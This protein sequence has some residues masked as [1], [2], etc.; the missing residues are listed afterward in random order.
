MAEANNYWTGLAANGIINDDTN[1]SSA[2][3]S[4]QVL[5]FPDDADTTYTL[6][7]DLS[8][9]DLSCVRNYSAM[10]FG[11]SASSTTEATHDFVAG[12][13]TA[14]ADTISE[15]NHG[16]VTGQA[17]VFTTTAAD[18]P[19]P[20]VAGT[21]Y[22]VIVV[23][24]DTYQ[25]ATSYAN[26][27]AGTQVDLTDGG[28]G[29][30]TAT[31][32][33]YVPVRIVLDGT[34]LQMLDKGSGTRYFSLHGASTVHL[35]GSGVAE[36]DGGDAAENTSLWIRHSGTL[37]L[38][39]SNSVPAIFATIKYIGGTGTVY[40]RNV[41]S[42]GGAAVPIN[43]IADT[44][45]LYTYSRLAAVSQ[46]AGI[47]RHHDG[48]VA[49]HQSGT[50]TS[51]TQESGSTCYYNSVGLLGGCDIHGKLDLST[52]DP[53]TKTVGVASTTYPRFY[54][55]CTVLDPAGVVTWAEEPEFV[56]CSIKDCVVDF[57]SNKKYTV[58]D[59]T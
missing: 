54:K 33:E 21:T 4:D 45:K 57:G 11:G 47:W 35:L 36:Y 32:L 25:V 29:T 19:D 15:V 43:L 7:G 5:I 6:K 17:I 52:E 40:L 18:L 49:T 41:T 38:G 2:L 28:S 55:G 48:G 53:R 59:I 27:I 22:Y 3:A 51:I 14:A 10:A 31:Y 12:D 20:L 34:T 24:A 46:I 8:P 9:W 16:M 23:D 44:V 30:H 39:P 26:A 1:W 50:V 58:A 42:T 13:V 37:T 56:G